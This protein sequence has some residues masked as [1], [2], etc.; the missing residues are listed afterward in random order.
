MK[1]QFYKT[2]LILSFS[3]FSL[4]VMG[5]NSESKNSS[6]QSGFMTYA[7]FGV[8]IFEKKPEQTYSN[9]ETKLELG[10]GMNMS[11]GIDYQLFLRNKW[12]LSFGLGYEYSQ[13]LRKEEYNYINNRNQLRGGKIKEKLQ[14]HNLILPIKSFFHH[15]KISVSLGV[16]STY[17][18][19]TRL[20]LYRA[21][22]LQE[23]L[24]SESTKT[25]K[26]GSYMET[27]FQ[28][29]TDWEKINLE[30]KFNFQ[31]VV[32]IHIPVYSQFQIDLEYRRYLT[33]NLLVSELKQYDVANNYFQYYDIFGGSFLIQLKWFLNH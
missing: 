4:I 12:S 15:K 6:P 17:H 29:L 3:F 19:A 31:G 11:T 14:S 25:L 32:G 20:N 7:K 10:T 16:I 22:F 23:D 33:Q 13:F 27:S 30:K 5:Q 28:G 1:I 2:F 18:L 24:V 26:D 8:G 21:F 9:F